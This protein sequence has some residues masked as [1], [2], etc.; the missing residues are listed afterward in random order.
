MAQKG[1]KKLRGIHTHERRELL[2]SI[3]GLMSWMRQEEK[4]NLN[5]PQKESY[6]GKRV[7]LG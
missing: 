5:Y 6:F 4:M 3:P 7:S 1:R 2:T